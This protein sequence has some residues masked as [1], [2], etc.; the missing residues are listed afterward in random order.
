MKVAGIRNF[1]EQL[2][3]ADEHWLHIANKRQSTMVITPI[4]KVR[5]WKCST[6]LV[7]ARNFLVLYWD[8]F[9]SMLATFQ[10]ILNLVLMIKSIK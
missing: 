4:R 2:F 3:V 7:P 9:R 10:N 8:Y 1:K 5:D 6:K